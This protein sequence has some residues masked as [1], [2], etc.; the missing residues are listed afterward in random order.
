MVNLSYVH[1]RRARRIIAGVALG[2]A[3]LMLVIG[4]IA[5]LGQKASPFTVKLSNAGANLSLATRDDADASESKIYLMAN[6]K[7]G[8]VPYCCY[9]E[10]FLPE[11]ADLD[12]WRSEPSFNLNGNKMTATRYFKYTFFVVNN[13]DQSADYDLELSL[14]NGYL[15][16]STGYGIDSVL[17]VRFYENRDLG[18]HDFTTYAKSASEPHIDPI[19][20]E[21][22]YKELVYNPTDEEKSQEGFVPPDYCEEFLSSSLLLKSHISNLEKGE[23]VRYTFVFWL[24]GSDR[25][26]E[27]TAPVESALIL[28][29]DISAHAS[30]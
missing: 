19:T 1:K 12:D 22:S 26:A 8:D 18:E 16:N 28:G 6:Q 5:L 23:K 3:A 24:E 17:R 14:H 9:H 20:N 25:Q 27:G 15:I 7:Y 29:V 11:H 21:K 30:K 4:A 2:S 13:G 10:P